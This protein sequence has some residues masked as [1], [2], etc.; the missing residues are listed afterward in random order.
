[1]KN[2]VALDAVST[3]IFAGSSRMVGAWATCGSKNGS[4]SA[5]PARHRKLVLNDLAKVS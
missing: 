2:R 1:V 5:R 4:I 3:P